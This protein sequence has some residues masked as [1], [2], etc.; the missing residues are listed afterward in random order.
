MIGN[1]KTTFES[2]GVKA[3]TRSQY[4]KTFDLLKK[5]EH[6]VV[7]QATLDTTA[8]EE[9]VAICDTDEKY[10]LIDELLS[11]FY[12]MDDEDYQN[13]IGQIANHIIS[14]KYEPDKTVI[15]A[16]A[17]DHET[18]GSQD[19]LNA[20]QIALELRGY[21]GFSTD[22][23]MDQKVEKKHYKK[24]IRNYVIVDDFVGTGR[25]AYNRFRTFV[26][27]LNKDDIHISFCVVSGM[28]FGVDYCHHNRMP[29]Y[30]PLQL[31]KGL[32]GYYKGFELSVK[33]YTMKE[34]EMN[35]ANRINKLELATY[36]MGWGKAEALFYREGRNVPNNV[37][38]IF[39]WKMYRDGRARNT[40][41]HRRQNGY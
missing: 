25:T 12:Y 5:Y 32:S 38:P 14:M 7:R 19:V 22:S 24:G 26:D 39:W 41:F 20:L 11:R 18:D 23:R 37:Y 27:N 9:L 13:K 6:I 8:L 30:C 17:H 1:R 15:M 40:L 21:N 16:M 2:M 34:L 28:K 36:T 4:D 3:Y 10:S 31:S 29:L 35:L 33:V